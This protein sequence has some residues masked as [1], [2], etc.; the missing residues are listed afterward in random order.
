MDICKKNLLFPDLLQPN[1]RFLPIKLQNEFLFGDIAIRFEFPNAFLDPVPGVLN[2]RI[3]RFAHP[4][5]PTYGFPT[6]PFVS[7]VTS[8][9]NNADSIGLQKVLTVDLITGLQTKISQIGYKIR[10]S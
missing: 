7:S 8:L 4:F 5:Q 6:L 10:I 9:R 2:P 1:S 3:Q